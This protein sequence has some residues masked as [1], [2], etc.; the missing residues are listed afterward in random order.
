MKEVRQVKKYTFVVYC[1]RNKTVE[2]EAESEDQAFEVMLEQLYDVNMD[3]ACESGDR[4]YQM[5]EVD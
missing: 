1:Q 4:T 2:V 3:D 5:L